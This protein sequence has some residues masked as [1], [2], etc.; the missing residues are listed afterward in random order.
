MRIGRIWFNF[1]GL[2]QGICTIENL[3]QRQRHKKVIQLSLSE[4]VMET[5]QREAC[6]KM[7]Q[8]CSYMIKYFGDYPES[9]WMEIDIYKVS[10]LLFTDINAAVLGLDVS[11]LESFIVDAWSPVLLINLDTD[12]SF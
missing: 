5:C 3:E 2:I 12:Q 4:A 7:E 10:K 8:L 11:A 1:S 6:I 9:E